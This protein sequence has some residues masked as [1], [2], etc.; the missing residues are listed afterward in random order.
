MIDL[1]ELERLA[2]AATPGP[3]VLGEHEKRPGIPVLWM[4]NGETLEL[5]IEGKNAPYF[6]AANPTAV[7]ELV[8]R[9]RVAEVIVRDL[10]ASTVDGPAS[11]NCVLCLKFY[12]P[13]D[14]ANPNAHHAESCPY[15]RAVEFTKTT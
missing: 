9:L 4:W 5:T 14:R 10:A 7:L 13:V 12:N 3:F 15:R 8:Q 2:R 11:N 1:D 6:A